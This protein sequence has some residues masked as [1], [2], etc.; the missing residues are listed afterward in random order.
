MGWEAATEQP[1]KLNGLQ[2]PAH[3]ESAPEW[4]APETDWEAPPQPQQ[5]AADWEWEPA[6]QRQTPQVPI[7]AGRMPH[8]QAPD[9]GW[10]PV[11]QTQI[12]Q[13]PPHAGNMPHQHMPNTEWG[14]SP[15]QHHRQ[16]TQQ[17]YSPQ[18]PPHVPDR[19]GS[20]GGVP[21]RRLNGQPVK[22]STRQEPNGIHHQNGIPPQQSDA[23]QGAP[24]VPLLQV[25][26]TLSA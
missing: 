3:A 12:Q 8:Q 18:V 19:P 26:E 21:P 10:E 23:N 4:Q 11:H 25:A 1:G 24:S 16:A 14:A 9:M 6:K 5:H 13:V 22:M 2:V 20:A 17:T 7:H 15:Q